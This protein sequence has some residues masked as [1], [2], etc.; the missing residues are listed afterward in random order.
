[1]PS[2][3]DD[4]PQQRLVELDVIAKLLK[5]ILSASLSLKAVL[6][7]IVEASKSIIPAVD[8]AAIHLQDE[9]NSLLRLEA[10]TGISVSPEDYTLSFGEGIAGLVL[11]S[12]ALVNVSDVSTDDRVASL[13]RHSGARALLVAPIKNRDSMTIGT[14]TLQ[15]STPGQFTADDEYL[16]TTLARQAGLA[17]ENTRL[18]E[19]AERGRRIAQLQRE[20]L[21]QLTRRMVNAQEAER[22]RIAQE[23][24]DEAGQSLTALKI[25]L[26]MLANGLSEDMQAERATLENA[27]ELAG[28]TLENLR[29]IS[30]NL[31]P[32][33]LDRLGLVLALEGL[34][35][36][37]EAMTNIQVS[38]KSVELP[39][40]ANSHE[41]TLY[42]FVQEALTNIAKHA[43]ATEV[44]V[45][46]EIQTGILNIYIADNGKGMQHNPLDL[47][48]AELDGMG[49]A[50]MEER[51]KNIKGNLEVQSAPGQGTRLSA[52]LPLQARQETT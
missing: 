29:L 48:Q 8:W 42:R 19:N 15:S 39:P 16:L 20:R 25:S 6:Q 45:W 27:A 38:C 32:A 4:L 21:R 14:I 9:L 41:I 51:L 22:K 18:Y 26:E 43:E 35:E 33:A 37:F 11:K 31:H 23:L 50:S 44:Q 10:V 3:H 47:D 17:I 2:T 24:H 30:H 5:E 34:C 46:L 12:G 13:P 36:N 7:Q 49:L 28:Q 40:L 1:M 52:R